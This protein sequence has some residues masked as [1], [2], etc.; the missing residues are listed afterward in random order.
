[1]ELP[2]AA[3]Y[4]YAALARCVDL[5]TP[6]AYHTPLRGGNA[7]LAASFAQYAALGVAASQLVPVFAWFGQ[8]TTCKNASAAAPGCAHLYPHCC[9]LR[10]SAEHL[11]CNESGLRCTATAWMLIVAQCSAI[12]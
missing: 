1:M 3:R 6:M 8:D 9:P 12:P 2:A 4:D 7:S 11:D 10:S 5:F